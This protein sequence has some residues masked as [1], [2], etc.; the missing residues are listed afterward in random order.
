ML[1]AVF[2]L[3]LLLFVIAAIYLVN[4][5]EYINKQKTILQHCGS[6]VPDVVEI[7]S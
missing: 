6:T 7:H 2:F 3:V 5:D 4:K 1:F